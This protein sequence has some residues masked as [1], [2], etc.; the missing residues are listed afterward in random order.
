[1]T[2]ESKLQALLV[3]NDNQQYRHL[4]LKTEFHNNSTAGQDRQ[5]QKETQNHRMTESKFPPKAMSQKITLF[6][7][8]LKPAQKVDQ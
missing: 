5:A 4:I 6:N 7:Y 1:L 8:Q 2:L 3:T